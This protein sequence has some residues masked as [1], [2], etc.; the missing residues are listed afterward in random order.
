M[1]M[2][3]MHFAII[4]FFLFTF[5]DFIVRVLPKSTQENIGYA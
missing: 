4:A 3:M 1:M 2:M 5:A